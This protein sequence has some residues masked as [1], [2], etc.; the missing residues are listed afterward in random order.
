MVDQLFALIKKGSTPAK[1]AEND[2]LMCCI[3]RVVI[4]AKRDILPFVENILANLTFV[5][6]EISKNPSNPKFNH[7]TFETLA[8]LIRYS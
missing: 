7:Y 6:R 3:W 4:A 2:Y 1:L 8:A 5:I